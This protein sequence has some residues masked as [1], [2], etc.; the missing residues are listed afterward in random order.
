MPRTK[1]DDYNGKWEGVVCLIW[2]KMAAM[3]LSVN[4][5][6]EKTQIKRGVL[7]RR[8]KKPEEFTLGELTSICRSL[9][10]PIEDVRSCVRY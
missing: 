9:H 7:Y 3:N 4:D 10:I 6:S 2:G 5:L 1:L 8:K